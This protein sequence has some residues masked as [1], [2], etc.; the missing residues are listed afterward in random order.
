LQ[1]ILKEHQEDIAAIITEELGK[2]KADAMGGAHP[3]MSLPCCQ[4]R[5]IPPGVL[6]LL[7]T[8]SAGSKSL[9]T[10]AR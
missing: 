10:R 1:H 2:T 7:Q 8:Y 9:S 4:R 5:L 6:S 3:A